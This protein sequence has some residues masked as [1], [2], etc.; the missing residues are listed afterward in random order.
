MRALLAGA[1]LALAFLAFRPILD[2]ES[3]AH[4]V[5]KAEPIRLS[6]RC[7]ETDRAS[8]A[9][10]AHFLQRNLPE[11]APILERATNALNIARRHC[12]RDWEERAIEN[13]EWLR[14]LLNDHS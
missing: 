8:A 13:Y 4:N 7:Q 6:L 9:Q 3:A 11:D 2:A 14:R 12:L 10:L 5:R 1:A